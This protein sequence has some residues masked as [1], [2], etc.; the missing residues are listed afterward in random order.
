MPSGGR[1]T[2]ADVLLGLLL[3]FA[4]LAGMAGSK[5]AAFP[6]FAGTS[7]TA[8]ITQAMPSYKLMHWL[9]EPRP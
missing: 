8:R 3:A 2:L 9:S 7:I 6:E 1:F 5:D 4:L